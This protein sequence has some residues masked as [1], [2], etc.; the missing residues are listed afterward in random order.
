Y[1]FLVGESSS[2]S[3]ERQMSLLSYIKRS[4]SD[5]RSQRKSEHNS[6]KKLLI[7][8]P[9]TIFMIEIIVDELNAKLFQDPNGSHWFCSC[10]KFCMFGIQIHIEYCRKGNS[11]KSILK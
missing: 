8:K 5:I 4:Y 10:I 6:L 11:L 9:I 1:Q 7:K 2:S 3:L